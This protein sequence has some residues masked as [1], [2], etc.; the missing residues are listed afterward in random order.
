MGKARLPFDPELAMVA[1][2]L[3]CRSVYFNLLTLGRLCCDRVGD[4]WRWSSER[5]DLLVSVDAVVSL[6][7]S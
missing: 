4:V 1:L 7:G 2:G 6:T 3:G 5:D